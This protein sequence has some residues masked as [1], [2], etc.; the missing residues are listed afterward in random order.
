MITPVDLHQKTFKSAGIGYS[1]ADVDEFF[2]S[3]EADYDQLYRELNEAK[4]LNTTYKNVIDQYKSIEK[5][6]EKAL[7][8]AEH[9]AEETIKSARA[10]AVTIEQEAV[11]KAEEIVADARIELESI[12]KKTFKLLTE[13]EAYREKF[14]AMANAQADF[15]SSR[16]FDIDVDDPDVIK[17][18]E[19]AVKEKAELIGHASSGDTIIIEG[20]SDTKVEFPDE[21]TADGSLYEEDSAG[22]AAEAP[23][24]D[25]EEKT[26]DGIALSQESFSQGTLATGDLADD[27]KVTITSHSPIPELNKDELKESEDP[28]DDISTAEDDAPLP[29]EEVSG[30]IESPGKESSVFSSNNEDKPASPNLAEITDLEKDIDEALMDINDGTSEDVQKDLSEIKIVV[31]AEDNNNEPSF[32]DTVDHLLGSD[33]VIN[34]DVGDDDTDSFLNSIFNE[35]E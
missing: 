19:K 23:S 14:K 25:Q 11:L 15:I 33:E 31:S 5:S 16:V 24:K 30:G 27:V 13:Y 17:E 6:L 32:S 4:K 12:K 22:N 8:L 18:I 20:L 26:E 10:N 7:L 34:D 29:F 3:I 2:N 9:T 21:V 28:S 1:K 35:K